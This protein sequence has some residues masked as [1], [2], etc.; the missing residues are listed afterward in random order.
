MSRTRRS[1]SALRPS[2]CSTRPPAAATQSSAISAKHTRGCLRSSKLSS[3]GSMRCVRLGSRGGESAADRDYFAPAPGPLWLRAGRPHEGR[4]L[5]RPRSPRPSRAHPPRRPSPPGHWREGPVR[6]LGL[7][8]ANRRPA[9]GGERYDPLIPLRPYRARSR[10]SG[11]RPLG[12]W[13]CRRACHSHSI[14][15]PLK[16]MSCLPAS[17]ALCSCGTT[18]F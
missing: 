5:R 18:A 16:L 8:P 1:H 2:S 15:Q 14:L 11:A 13:D 9:Q 6:Q 3:M 12:A 4:R 10:L 17:V 7:H